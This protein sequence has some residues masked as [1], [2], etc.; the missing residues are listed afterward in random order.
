MTEQP[1]QLPSPVLV[2]GL[3]NPLLK[4]DG[5]GLELMRRLAA[6]E[7]AESEKHRDVEYMD[8]GTQGVALLGRFS[9]REALLIL[10]AISLGEEREP[11]SIVV[12]RD[13]LT[14]AAQ[15]GVGAHGAN[16]S[17]L[18]A[19]AHLLGD[20]PPHAVIV[21]VSPAQLETG[22]GLSEPIR[23]ALPAAV[24]AAG[25]IL[26]EL[27]DRVRTAVEPAEGATPCTS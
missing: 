23:K 22:I 2:L 13:P 21:G 12:V 7:T 16:A 27:C 6:R 11:G 5:V 15:Q 14:H 26:D 24:E 3:G 18:L 1:A 4:D 19:A 25:R 20:L 17:G 9:G 10:D 8:G